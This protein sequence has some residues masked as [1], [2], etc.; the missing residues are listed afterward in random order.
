MQITLIYIQNFVGGGFENDAV[1]ALGGGAGGGAPLGLKG[2][3]GQ[4][5]V[6]GNIVPPVGGDGSDA[7]GFIGGIG[8]TPN[9]GGYYGGK[10]GDIGQNG[11]AGNINSIPFTGSPATAYGLA[12]VAGDYSIVGI[13]NVTLNNTG[14]IIGATI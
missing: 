2:I 13:S 7:I 11:E 3:G 12:G 1:F 14:T 4:T 10:G 9:Q 6:S 5:I 8:G